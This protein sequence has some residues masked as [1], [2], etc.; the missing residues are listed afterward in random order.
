MNTDCI[1]YAE[2]GGKLLDGWCEL[3]GITA[4]KGMSGLI[5]LVLFTIFVFWIM[6]WVRKK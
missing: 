5:I 1:I 3:T 2:Y 6:K 4:I